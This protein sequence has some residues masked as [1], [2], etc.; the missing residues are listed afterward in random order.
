MPTFLRLVNIDYYSYLDSDSDPY[1]RRL[2]PSLFPSVATVVTRC[3]FDLLLIYKP[4]LT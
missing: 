2:S 1:Q 3:C 4:F